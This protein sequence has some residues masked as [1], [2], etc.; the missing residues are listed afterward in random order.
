[1][2]ETKRHKRKGDGVFN[3]RTN[4]VV[5][6]DPNGEEANQ[7][8]VSPMEAVKGDL[9]SLRKQY[10][11]QQRADPIL[12]AF[13]S[14]GAEDHSA[15]ETMLEESQRIQAGLETEIEEA[16]N[17]CQ[18]ESSVLASL[19]I[20]NHQLVQERDKLVR[21][22]DEIDQRQ[23]HLQKQ[24]ALHHQEA[25]EEIENI[26]EVE[27]ERKRE[28]PRMKMQISLYASTT[29]IKWDFSQDGILSGSVVSMVICPRCFDP[30][31]GLFT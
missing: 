4:H 27:E 11:L 15:L 10:D 17:A 20:E 3:E 5:R 8:D 16:R 26:D 29:G 2:G 23:V 13:R 18:Q 24:I 6:V 1:M 30:R 9:K 19:S 14:A 28:V 12:E 31:N 21:N 22:M 25:T 7:R